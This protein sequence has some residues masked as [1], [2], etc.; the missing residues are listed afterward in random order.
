MGVYVQDIVMRYVLFSLLL[1]L[2]NL[3][4]SDEELVLSK[5]SLEYRGW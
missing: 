5:Y 1:P 4:Q 2:Q 3:F